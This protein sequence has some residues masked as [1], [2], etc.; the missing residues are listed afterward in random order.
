MESEGS[1]LC[2]YELDDYH[3]KLAISL[4]QYNLF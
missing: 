4:F 1:L 3:N 2:S